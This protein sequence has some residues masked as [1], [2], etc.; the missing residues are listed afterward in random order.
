[1]NPFD[2][3]DFKEAAQLTSEEALRRFQTLGFLW[4]RQPPLSSSTDDDSRT[5]TLSVLQ[6]I[7]Q[8]HPEALERKWSVENCGNFEQETDLSPSVVLAAAADSE[9]S[10]ATTTKDSIKTNCIDNNN[11]N[12]FYV[13]TIL[14]RR[15]DKESIQTLER[16]A[17]RPYYFD[18]TPPL[19]GQSRHKGGAW[20]FLGRNCD[21]STIKRTQSDHVSKK[22]KLALTNSTAKPLTGRAEHVD[23]VLHSGTWH[24]QLAGSKTW[25]LRPNPDANAWKEESSDGVPDLRQ[26]LPDT[27][28]SE[29]N[30][31]HVQVQQSDGG[32]V[33]LCCHVQQGDF[34]VLNT[35]AWYHRTELPVNNNQYNSW[36][37]SMARDFNLP[38]PPLVCEDDVGQ[39]E[40]IL[41]ED[42]IPEHFPRTTEQDGR[43]IEANC[44]LAEVFLE[45]DQDGTN[46]ADGQEEDEDTESPIVLVA[47]RDVRKGEPLVLQRGEEDVES[48]D[49]SDDGMEE[50]DNAPES[51][52]PRAIAKTVWE[53]GDIVLRGEEMPEEL[54]LS[55]DPNCQRYEQNGTECVRCLRPIAISDVL[56]IAPDDGDDLGEFE[57][58][59]VDLTSGEMQR[60]S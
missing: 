53:Q 21:I 42:D 28:R 46:S 8:D 35:R 15:H 34:F 44:A 36:S 51:I 29:K 33:R 40:V 20:L 11:L 1:M 31:P 38:E 2:R 58:V 19:L 52:D 3:L 5:A 37:I 49:E 23:E 6:T 17:L 39:G 48:D 10:K 9:G 47:L 54:P 25:Y 18:T 4:I 32:Q 30:M 55:L 59:E 50:E 14:S 13:S 27:T 24:V 45:G 7:Y 41:E 26:Y 16:A 56:T 60:D 43:P 12:R 22:Q 57:T